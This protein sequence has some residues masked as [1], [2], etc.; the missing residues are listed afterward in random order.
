MNWTEK[1]LRNSRG[2]APFAEAY[3]QY[4]TE[5][6][7]ELSRESI[8]DFIG[9]LESARANGNTVFL[10]GNG[11]SAAT[12][13]HMAND[14]S[15]GVNRVGIGPPLRALALTDSV[16]CLTAVANDDGYEEIFVAQLKVHYKP[17]DKL[18]AISASGNSPNVLAAVEW[19]KSRGGMVIGLLGF[20]GGKLKDLCNLVIHIRTPQGAYGPVEDVHMVLNHLVYTWLRYHHKAEGEEG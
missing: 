19:V 18:V 7:S 9:E 2:P 5:L 4:L 10:V 12:A 3:L 8:V 13:S 16:A 6:L 14:L 1:L 20:D 15:I 11:G 17:G